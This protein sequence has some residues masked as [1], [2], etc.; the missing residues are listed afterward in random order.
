ARTKE[1][2]G[3]FLNQ[4][5]H[6]L[7]NAGAFKRT[8]EQLGIPFAGKRTEGGERQAI[9]QGELHRLPASIA[10]LAM[11]SLMG[12]GDKV[13]FARL[14]KAVIDGAT[15]KESFAMWLD[16]EDLSPVVRMGMEAIAR[17]SSYANAPALSH[18][19]ELLE[20]MRRA[21]KGVIYLDGGW[22]TLVS[23]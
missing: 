5:P 13:T 17:V 21:F 9:Y 18:A 22:S 20:Q 3:F 23:G 11:T 6:A 2:D 1:A 16:G 12:V 4:G 15:G 10:T 19:G 7:Y 14:Q 8:L